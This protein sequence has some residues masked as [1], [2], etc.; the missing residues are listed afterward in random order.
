MRGRLRLAQDAMVISQSQLKAAKDLV[1][2]A[3]QA[4]DTAQGANIAA[5]TRLLEVR[6]RANATRDELDK[7]QSDVDRTRIARN[8]ARD[9]YR[10]LQS[11]EADIGAQVRQNTAVSMALRRGQ[12]DRVD[13]RQ[14]TRTPM[15]A[16][17]L[18]TA[19]N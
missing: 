16:P 13:A 10:Y 4:H 3:D 18:P 17:P 19:G 6:G 15:P 11:V 14:A 12:W 2:R 8:Q 5:Q 9:R 7:A 1:S